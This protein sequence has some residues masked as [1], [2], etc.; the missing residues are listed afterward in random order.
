VIGSNILERG[1]YSRVKQQMLF[2]LKRRPLTSPRWGFLKIV[3]EWC[4]LKSLSVNFQ[5]IVIILKIIL[6]RISPYQQLIF[7]I[8]PQEPPFARVGHI[9]C[10]EFFMS[11]NNDNCLWLWSV[12][13][14]PHISVTCIHVYK[15]STCR[16]TGTI[17]VHVEANRIHDIQKYFL[18]QQIHNISKFKN[19]W[20]KLQPHFLLSWIKYWPMTP[21]Y[22][23]SVKMKIQKNWYEPSNK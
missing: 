1:H 14:S 15:R 20:G 19:W 16:T 22:T 7:K 3:R 21:L 10:Y 2:I 11:Y 8:W 4:I 5:E 12:G 6:C 9:C 13:W 23:W 18:V 17:H